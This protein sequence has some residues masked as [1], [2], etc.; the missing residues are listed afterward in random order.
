MFTHFFRRFLLICF[1][2]AFCFRISGQP[3]F[4]QTSRFLKANGVWAFGDSTG[5]NFNAGGPTPF[6]TSMHT[7]ESAASIADPQTGQLL[8]YTDAMSCWDANNQLMP[9]GSDLMGGVSNNFTTHQGAC[10]VPVIGTTNQYYIFSLNFIGLTPSLFYSVVDM[11]LNGGLGDVVVGQKAILLNSNSLS[12]GMIAIPGDNCDIWLL[13][14]RFPEAEFIAYHITSA[15]IDPNPVVSATGLNAQRQSMI[16]VSSDR[17]LVAM[18]NTRIAVLPNPGVQLGQFDPATGI[19]SNA[20]RIDS[21]YTYGICFSPDNSK[22]YTSYRIRDLTVSYISYYPIRQYDISSFNA[23]T[24]ASTAIDID[25]PSVSNPPDLKLYHDTIYLGMSF[26]SSLARINKPNLSG[27]ACDFQADAVPLLADG[28]NGMVIYGLCNTVVFPM[29]PDT[30]RLLSLDTMVCT[31]NQEP[32]S[33][34]L[35]S[36]P[37]Y[38]GYIWDDNSTG[39]V[40]TVSM[41]GTYWVLG[42]DSCHSRMDSFIIRQ[43]DLSVSLGNDTVLCDETFALELH[44]D[45]PGAAYLWQNG[46]KEDNYTASSAGTYWVKVSDSGCIA[47]DTIHIEVQPFRQ[48]LGPDML[49]CREEPVHVILEANAPAGSMVTWNT[50]SHD[51]RIVV[52]DTGSYWVYVADQYCSAGDTVHIATEACDCIFRMPNAFTPNGDGLNDEL[53]PGLAAGCA[54][55]GFAFSVYNRY[56][57]R[58]FFSANSDK[59]WDGTFNGAPEDAGTYFFELRFTGGRRQLPYYQ[60]GDV[61]LIR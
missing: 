9:N 14:H 56:G 60:K 7:D 53:K 43:K 5:L 40:R 10:I 37:G 59:G 46:S 38:N 4:N 3:Y 39:A 31:R 19:V 13:L 34:T 15:G 51:P 61:A 55:S 16:A 22:L 6:K 23:A 35:E 20:F 45:L 11:S 12:E 26:S 28:R 33:L 54:A 30:S 25:T 21:N 49:L 32:F 36:P 24:I 42:M 48:D 58:V 44:V 17:R 57:Q 50:G 2:S 47:A 1:L 8:F 29:P 52:Q 41:P 18:A 27:A